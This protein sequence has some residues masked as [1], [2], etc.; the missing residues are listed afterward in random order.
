MY[1]GNGTELWNSVFR[2]CRASVQDKYTL[3][4]IVT[5]ALILQ[6]V[7]LSPSDRL[8]KQV[9]LLEHELS[10]I[11][12]VEGMPSLVL[13]RYRDSICYI[14]A[15]YQVK[16]QGRTAYQDVH[17]TGTGFV[18]AD[19]LVA[20]SRH[21]AQPWFRDPEA[22]ILIRRGAQVRIKKLLAFFP[23]VA[24]P[25]TLNTVALSS[26]T[27]LALLSLGH[28]DGV[29]R[30]RS[31]PLADS[32]PSPG[33]FISVIGYPMGIFGMVA[34]SP[35]S[36]YARLASRND[37]QL[38]ARELAALSLIRPSATCGHLGDVVGDK[39]I[40]DAATTHGGSGGPVFD[41]AGRVIAVNDAYMEG[42]S[43]ATLGI[44]I[45]SLS[46]LIEAAGG[47]IR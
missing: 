11:K 45:R 15:T 32:L 35:S 25:V 37:D 20:T 14:I 22:A 3:S 29:H 1:E 21:I 17:V 40:Y 31:L 9:E 27:D 41:S 19:G 42:F 2:V 28:F 34:K 43:G 5:L 46:R 4:L 12:Q 36:I 38:L 30:L 24:V 26:E 6:N 18:V 13:N 7:G 44:S 8:Q 39:L 10:E 16:L 33:E 47:S 23:G